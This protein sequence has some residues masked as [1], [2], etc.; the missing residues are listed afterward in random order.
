MTAHLSIAPKKTAKPV[1]PP[2]LDAPAR[3]ADGALALLQFEA[4]IRRQDTPAEL[5]FHLANEMRRA[6]PFRQAFL[7][8][9]SA[10]EAPALLAISSL[11]SVEH[12]APLAQWV[13]STVKALREDVGLSKVASFDTPA[14]VDPSTVEVL[15]PFGHLMWL[16]LR[17]RE[18]TVFAG[19]LLAEAKPWRQT[20]EVIGERLADTYAHAWQA[21]QRGSRRW[22]LR[23]TR[24]WTI[25]TVLVIAAIL[26]LP[27]RLSALAPV[28]VVP[29]RP[30]VLAA[31]LPGVVDKVHVAP[32]TAVQVGDLLISFEDTRLR[33]EQALAE[34]RLAVARARS[35]RSSQA[36]FGSPEASHE[37]AINKAELDLVQ[38]EYQYASE[39]LLN[40]RLK[41]P[42]AGVVVYGDRRDLEGRP[43]EVGQQ[44]LQIANPQKVEFRIDL[45]SRDSAVISEGA[46]VTLYLDSAP[47]HPI[48]ARLARASYQARPTAD[49]VL[50]YT[51]TAQPAPGS[52]ALRIGSRGTAQVYG[53]QVPLVYKILR[54]P[55][56]SLR[57]W[58]GF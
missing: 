26:A 56:A 47:L 15:Y 43:V 3:A 30:V 45:P 2:A 13:R 57:Q 22:S 27:V 20:D 50:S 14:Y 18:G 54:R 5:Q 41:A 10:T 31:P 40:T 8:T 55:L 28:E 23:W 35:L 42:M 11:T 34:Q 37:V 38:T 32:N 19:A 9:V 16:P 53:Q 39:L 51:L 4:E 24:P 58:T 21:L 6:L 29:A 36:A 17:D 49:K 7:L 46:E 25:A 1:P 48:Q 12:D 52:P 44:L 33:N